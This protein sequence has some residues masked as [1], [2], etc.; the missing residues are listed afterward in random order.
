MLMLMLMLTPW[1]TW[2]AFWFTRSTSCGTH[3]AA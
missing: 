3:E 1:A 2:S